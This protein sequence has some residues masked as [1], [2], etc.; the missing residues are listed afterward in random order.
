[1]KK[2]IA[3]GM[4][5][6]VLLVIAASALSL[7][8]LLWSLRL[9][10]SQEGIFAALEE[11]GYTEAMK[12]DLKK[13]CKSLCETSGIPEELIASFI[14]ETV[15][16]EVAYYPLKALFV[17]QETG[18]RYEA[19][20]NRLTERITEYARD[21]R[22][23]GKMPLSDEE[24]TEMEKNFPET[25][26]Y[27]VEEIRSSV[28]LSGVYSM[29]GSAIDLVNL[30]TRYLVVGASFA[31]LVS[32]FLLFLIWKRALLMWCYTAFSSAGLLVFVPSALIYVKDFVSGLGL[33]PAYFKSLIC[34]EVMSLCRRLMVAGGI[35]LA[36]GI[37][38]GVAN[39]T[40]ALV[41]KQ[42]KKGSELAEK[43]SLSEEKAQL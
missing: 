6:S 23:S 29:L 7:L 10:F 32:L 27:F 28:N 37:L 8:M 4:I 43:T 25:A 9:P 31:L 26:S 40:V 2:K 21:L 39:L 35:V 14:E 41:I 11:V 20:Q 13:D 15:V 18:N 33:E 34:F 22:E 12:A 19:M 1:M 38:C 17:E 24:W 42:K 30:L 5:T 3:R 16:D 36:L